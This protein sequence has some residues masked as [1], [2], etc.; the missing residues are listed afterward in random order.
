MKTLLGITAIAAL[1]VAACGSSSPSGQGGPTVPT[2]LNGSVK[3]SFWERYCDDGV[4]GAVKRF[5]Q[6]QAGKITVTDVCVGGSETNLAAKIQ[7]AA[8]GGGLPDIATAGEQYA[9]QYAKANLLVPLD[10]YVNSA[11]WGVPASQRADFYPNPFARTKLA[12]YGN[13]TLS[14]P[15]GN[16]ANALYVNLDLLHQAG[17]SQAPTTWPEFQADAQ[18]IKQRTGK[19][20]WVAAPGDGADLLDAVWSSGTP[21]VNADGKAQLDAP[22]TVDVLQSWQTLFKDHSAEVSNDYKAAFTGG[23]AGMVFASTG[24]ATTWAGKVNGFSWNIAMFPHGT[25]Q[26]PLT[27]LFGSVDV[28]F[29][30]NP[31]KQLASWLFAKYLAS[32]DNQ[33]RMCP[34]EGCLPA[35]KSSATMTAITDT[36]AKIPQYGTAI[37]DIAPHAKLLPQA[38]ALSDIR[39]KIAGDV[40]TR[41]INGM[42]PK[43]AAQQLQQ[44]AQQAIESS[45]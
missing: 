12:V 45:K 23:N 40:I 10:T 43:Q 5:N 29:H 11:Q 3:I 8:R 21:W 9:A 19:P 7:A 4:A 39:G 20:G 33:A 34:V 27:E 18:A 25:G 32:A 38:P 15:F 16:T 28:V 6:Q 2:S 41:V 17:I 14:W 36:T 31:Q 24:Y 13:R 35:T 42:A 30:S 44:Q 26:P 37:N 1:L 22:A